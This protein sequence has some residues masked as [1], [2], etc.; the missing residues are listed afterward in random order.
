MGNNDDPLQIGI[1]LV[2]DIE[3]ALINIECE[4]VKVYGLKITQ[5]QSGVTYTPK[6]EDITSKRDRIEE[7]RESL[8]KRSVKYDRLFPEVEKFIANDLV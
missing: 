3:E 8:M 5:N 2:Y 7:F 1:S 4:E 6:V